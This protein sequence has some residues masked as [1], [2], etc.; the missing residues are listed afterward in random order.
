MEEKTSKNAVALRYEPDKDNAP[1][2]VAKG[3]GYLAERIEEVARENGVPL[4]EDKQLAEYLMSLDLYDEIPP[5]LYAVVAEI[6]AFIYSVD[7]KY[8]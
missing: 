2:V 8:E 5:E 6:L 7:R 3:R 4:K 1:L